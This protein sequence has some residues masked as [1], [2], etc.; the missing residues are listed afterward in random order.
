MGWR[1][2]PV[3]GTTHPIKCICLEIH[4]SLLAQCSQ[5]HFL[6]YLFHQIFI[7]FLAPSLLYFLY[8]WPVQ[9]SFCTILY[10][11]VR[12]SLKQTLLTLFNFMRSK[13]PVGKTEFI[14]PYVTINRGVSWPG[15]FSSSL[16]PT[17]Q[18]Q[19]LLCPPS[20]PLTPLLTLR[21][22][23]YLFLLWLLVYLTVL[24]ISWHTGFSGLVAACGI[25]ICGMWDLLPDQRLNPCPPAL[26]AQSFSHWNTQGKSP[27]LYSQ[28]F[29]LPGF[30]ISPDVPPTSNFS[31]CY[32]SLKP[33]S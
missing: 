23:L 13:V 4:C 19:N 33:P 15:S 14:A 30:M 27:L 9:N 18:A 10:R 32:M 25:Y 2:R 12:I 24:T 20:I 3:I 22:Q 26:G 31:G 21:S 29:L 5:L 17:A 1:D 28:S 7:M 8:S 11:V 6:S 16:H